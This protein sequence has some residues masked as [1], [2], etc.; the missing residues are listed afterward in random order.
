MT[1][2]DEHIDEITNRAAEAIKRAGA[3]SVVIISTWDGDEGHSTKHRKTGRGNYYAQRGSVIEWID[4]TRELAPVRLQE[5]P[6]E[7]DSWKTA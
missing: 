4:A 7:A 6:D 5:P 3:E 2:S 1:P